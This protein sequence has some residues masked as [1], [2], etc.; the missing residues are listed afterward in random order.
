M[1]QDERSAAR[2][3][4]QLPP[5]EVD[6]GRVWNELRPRIRRL[7]DEAL[8]GVAPV[9]LS[10]Y[11]RLDGT[12]PFTSSPSS[13]TPHVPGSTQL[14]RALEFEAFTNLAVAILFGKQDLDATLTALAAL[15]SAADQM[16]YS[17]GADAFAMTPLTAFARTL[18]DDTTALQ[19]R[20]TLG[21]AAATHTHSADQVTLD[22]SGWTGD[23]AGKGIRDVQ[24]L[25]DYLD[26]GGGGP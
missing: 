5:P 22:D 12:T 16:I 20:A 13:N 18:L 23:L 4:G 1:V 15:V 7:I 2:G 3:P 17:T 8:G 11:A 9:D 10:D 19:A 25:A 24:Q 26:G 14:V 21:A 6:V